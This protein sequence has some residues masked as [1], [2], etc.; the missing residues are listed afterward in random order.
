MTSLVDAGRWLLAALGLGL[1]SS[2]ASTVIDVGVDLDVDEVDG[3][4]PRLARIHRAPDGRFVLGASN[5]SSL[6]ST[7]DDGGFLSRSRQVAALG[8]AA[9]SAGVVGGPGRSSW[10]RPLV[11][12]PSN[13]SLRSDGSGES[14]AASRQ[15]RQPRHLLLT[16]AIVHPA[17]AH[18]HYANQRTLARSLAPSVAAIYS[19]RTPR[20]VAS[21]PTGPA[22]TN[23]AGPWWPALN[24]SDLSSVRT[25]PGPATSYQQ[26]RSVHERYALEL[27]S[28][29]AIHEQQQH[30]MLLQQ[31]PRPTPRP[32]P[33]PRH[34]FLPIP[35]P[36]P[37]RIRIPEH[38]GP[39][40][41]P[42]RATTAT[43]S[44]WATP[45]ALSAHAMHVSPNA[46]VRARPLTRPHGHVYGPV[47]H[48]RSAP[49]L[50]GMETSPE[51]RS[52]SSGFGSKNT[53][54]Q[55]NQSGS[56]PG[57]TPPYRHPPA[58]TG[59][60]GPT[61]PSTSRAGPSQGPSPGLGLHDWLAI[62]A[63][64]PQ[65]PSPSPFQDKQG[66]D[67]SVDGHYEFDAV[68]VGTPTRDERGLSDSE[69]MFPTTLDEDADVSQS[70]D[71]FSR[72]AKQQDIEARVQAMKE[73]FAAFRQRQARRRRSPLLESV[74]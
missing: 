25:P 73:E 35:S 23:T 63:G 71:S 20:V 47:R 19:P 67:V 39:D 3:P 51:S 6:S 74:C 66:C 8:V 65:R 31:R 29:T 33:Q 53:S 38:G 21:S 10:R 43:A 14:G 60:V 1:G 56:L 55:P 50:S 30:L 49:E 27:P 36:S 9:L 54:S 46:S 52:S 26:L 32:Q 72:R 37:P 24:F 11:R 69:T 64:L 45:G 12:S 58:P 18:H 22:G 13:L 70:S 15:P 34:V 62:T 68:F 59:T 4:G 57:S 41:P 7:S 2:R 16:T 48:A 28:L 5:R 42:S 61:I 17:H 40:G 44:P